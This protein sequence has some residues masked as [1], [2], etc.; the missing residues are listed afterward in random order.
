[1]KEKWDV[2][3]YHPTT[4]QKYALVKPT[5]KLRRQSSP[6]LAYPHFLELT[7]QLPHE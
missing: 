7:N 6:R 5:A 2:A 1:M 3:N 4:T